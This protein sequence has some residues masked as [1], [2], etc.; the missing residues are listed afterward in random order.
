MQ[1]ES[2][3]SNRGSDSIGASAFP[4]S[5]DVV[6]VRF[7][8]GERCCHAVIGTIASGFERRV[9]WVQRV[10]VDTGKIAGA[11]QKQA[12]DRHTYDGVQLFHA[13]TASVATAGKPKWQ[14]RLVR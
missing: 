14:G 2:G 11:G 13:L 1:R 9:T 5:G 8:G 7:A 6:D 12:A 3:S 4:A 10:E